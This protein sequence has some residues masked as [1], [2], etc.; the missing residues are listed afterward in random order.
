VIDACIAGEGSA[1]RV[2]DVMEIS[3]PS[4]VYVSWF[5]VIPKNHK[6]GKWWFIV[7]LSHP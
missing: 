2:S 1:G 5:E 3:N 7:D 4:R 6:P